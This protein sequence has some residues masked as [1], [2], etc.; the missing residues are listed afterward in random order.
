MKLFYITHNSP[1]GVKLTAEVIAPTADEA[2]EAFY[3]GQ[4]RTQEIERSN[5]KKNKFI[6]ERKKV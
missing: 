1:V 4:V 6:I 2:V 5:S 3:K